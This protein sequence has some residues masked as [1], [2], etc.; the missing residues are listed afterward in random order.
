MS[1]P[2]FALSI[3]DCRFIYCRFSIA[4]CRLRYRD[5]DLE[6]PQ[7]FRPRQIGNRQSKIGNSLVGIG[8]VD[9]TGA[10]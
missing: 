2:L 7:H 5:S 8:G 9:A 3:F 1:V 4:D 6:L 10:R